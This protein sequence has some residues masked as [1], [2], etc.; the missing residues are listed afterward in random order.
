MDAASLYADPKNWPVLS[1]ETFPTEN[2]RPIDPIL[3]T[4][5]E[6]LPHDIR[7][8]TTTWGALGSTRGGTSSVCRIIR[9]HFQIPTVVHLPI[10]AK[11][12]QDIESILRGLHL[13]GLHNV[14]ALGGDPPAGRVDYV[15]R[16]LRHG[17][18]SDLVKQIVH[19]N[20]GLWMDG[21]GRYTKVGVK[22]QFGIGVAGFPEVHP[23]DYRENQD[24]EL[25]MQRN[26]EHLKIK[27]DS[28]AQY[29]V[30][31]MSFDADLHFRFAELARD[32]GIDVP[33]IPGLLPFERYA[34][35]ARFVGEEYRVSMPAKLEADLQNAPEEDQKQIA[36]DHMAG[37]LKK[38]LDSGVPG[39]HFY[40]M[41]KSAP[42]I[43]LLQ[44]AR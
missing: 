35:V 12:R 42:T 15:P 9:N 6:L 20:G 39:I 29:I 7:I 32:A 26:I 21:H 31:Q 14:L 18:A 13:D 24:F 36:E 3:K 33:I 37:V 10:Q 2:F 19:L 17:Y 5:E 25:N 8:V 4:V 27:V 34:Q 30:E 40:C 22:T 23:D 44:R 11:T 41:N 38:L 1:A 16:Q 43:R 28:G